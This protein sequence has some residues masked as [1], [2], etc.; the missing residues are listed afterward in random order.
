[1]S[2]IPPVKYIQKVM[3][4]TAIIIIMHMRIRAFTLD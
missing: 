1:M 2:S 4:K 3:L